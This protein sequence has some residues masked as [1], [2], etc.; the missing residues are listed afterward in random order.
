VANDK[1]VAPVEPPSPEDHE[2]AFGIVAREW[3]LGG[4][5]LPF[6]AKLTLMRAAVDLQRLGYHVS[7]TRIPITA[8]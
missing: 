8:T 2:I 7:L 4:R 1:H 5:S 6:F 3:E